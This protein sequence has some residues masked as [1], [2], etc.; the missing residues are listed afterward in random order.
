MFSAKN[1]SFLVNTVNP[2]I[3][4]MIE[5]KNMEKV[6]ESVGFLFSFLL[7]TAVLHLILA[8]LG[9][10]GWSSVVFTGFI[11]LAVT[12]AGLAIRRSLK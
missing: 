7:F 8:F 10:M 1:G 3:N 9:K 4:I 11:T 5:N 6:G 2:V 12:V